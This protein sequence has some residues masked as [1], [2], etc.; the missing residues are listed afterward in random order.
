[1]KC[2]NRLKWA[3]FEALESTEATTGGVLLKICF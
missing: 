3:K 1:M 2:N